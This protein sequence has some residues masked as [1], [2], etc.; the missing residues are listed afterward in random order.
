VRV[1]GVEPR[2]LEQVKRIFESNRTQGNTL[3]EVARGGR[4]LAIVLPQAGRQ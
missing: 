3:L 1:D 2:S 4:H